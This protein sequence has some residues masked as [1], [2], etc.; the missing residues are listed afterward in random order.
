MRHVFPLW[1]GP[2]LENSRLQE[3]VFCALNLFVI[4]FLVLA[5]EFLARVWGP[6]TPFLFSLMCAGFLGHLLL[7]RWLLVH[8]VCSTP[9]QLRFT[10]IS[11]L[12][13]TILTLAASSTN[14]DDSQYYIL[15]AVP[16]LQA[17]F[18]YSL[19]PTIAV[20]L[21]ADFLNFFWLYQYIHLHSGSID[22][23]EYIEASTICFIYSVTGIVVWILVNNLR[24]KEF[25]LADSLEQLRRTRSHLLEE[26]KLAVVGRLSASIANQIRSPLVLISSSLSLVNK[27]DISA[28]ERDSLLNSIAHESARLES[29]VSDFVSYSQPPTIDRASVNLANSL[30]AVA[31]AASES[32]ASRNIKLSVTAPRELS[33]LVDEPKT[34]SAL[35]QLLAHAIDQSPASNTIYLRA[36]ARPDGGVKFIVDY[37]GPRLTAASL[38]ELFDPFFE[39]DSYHSGLGLAVARNI[40]RAQGGEISL[41]PSPDSRFCF[42]A[43]LPA[44]PSPATIPVES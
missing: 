38:P 6:I 39:S 21:L 26:E 31:A 35:A 43:E 40:F 27:P 3:L 42:S 23:D 11:I 14:R 4:F 34:R 7:L 36:D 24:R 37:A 20:V 33:A 41:F 5:N 8:K 32:A 2:D 12:I 44:V 10:T 13:N 30:R 16:V 19:L 18:R 1:H 9:A 22:V 28:S 29:L 25:F 15:M 17:A